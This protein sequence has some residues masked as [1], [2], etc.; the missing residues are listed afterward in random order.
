[1][2]AMSDLILR[3]ELSILYRSLLQQKAN[4]SLTTQGECVFDVSNILPAVSQIEFSDYCTA[5]DSKLTSSD[6][7]KRAKE[8]WLSRLDTLSG[9]TELPLV[10]NTTNN[11]KNNANNTPQSNVLTGRFV[12]YHR[13]LTAFEWRRAKKNCTK[14][15]VTMPAVLLAAYSIVLYK[16]GNCDSFLINILQCLRHQVHEDVNK[17]VGNCSSTILCDINFKMTGGEKLTFK[18][19][20]LRIAQELSQNLEHASMSGVEVMQELNRKH[21]KT[22]KAVAP[23]IFTTPIG[24]EKGK[25]VSVFCVNVCG[26]SLSIH[27]IFCGI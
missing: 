21:G 12:N 18:T 27:H 4:H 6:E 25:V 2:D 7:H 19:A 8:Y 10:T 11:T 24:V 20:V 23:F 1:M 9:S 14:H 3:Q 22:F 26:F 16:Y 5:L 13:W 15:L 17:M